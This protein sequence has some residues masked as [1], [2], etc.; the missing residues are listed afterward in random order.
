VSRYQCRR[1][2]HTYSWRGG[3]SFAAVCDLGRL[4]RKHYAAEHPG[5]EAG[6]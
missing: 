5:V 1:C 3:I 4:I 2:G 6:K